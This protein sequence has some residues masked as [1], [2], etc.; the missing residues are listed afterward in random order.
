MITIME[1]KVIQ[2]SD[3]TA[4]D[5][6]WYCHEVADW[7]WNAIPAYWSIG[8]GMVGKCV[9]SFAILSVLPKILILKLNSLSLG[10]HSFNHAAKLV[11]MVLFYNL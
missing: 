9:W 7:S 11:D 3:K 8:R 2:G 4:A 1:I 10:L 6:W 5:L